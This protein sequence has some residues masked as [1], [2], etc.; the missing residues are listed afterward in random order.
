MQQE[1][2]AAS[3]SLADSAANQQL[4]RE[5]AAVQPLGGLL[6][7]RNQT[8]LLSSM[9]LLSRNQTRLLSSTLLLGSNSKSWSSEIPMEI[10]LLLGM[11]PHVRRE[12]C[13]AITWL[14]ERG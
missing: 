5:A 11:D 1:G 10:E 6:L 12:Q 3:D 2:A 8:R 9:L 14:V 4:R 7:S 13:L